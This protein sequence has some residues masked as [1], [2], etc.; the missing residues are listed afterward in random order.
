M[1]AV[2]DAGR[3]AAAAVDCWA[4]SHSRYGSVFAVVLPGWLFY[5]ACRVERLLI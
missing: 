2:H 1:V 5:K 3:L 4:D